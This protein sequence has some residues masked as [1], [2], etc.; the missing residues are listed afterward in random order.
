MTTVESQINQAN[1]LM[2]QL[3]WAEAIQA[4]QHVLAQA[5]ENATVWF[6]LAYALRQYGQLEGALNCYAK[7]LEYGVAQ[8]EESYTNRA[9]ILADHLQRSDDAKRELQQALATNP[10]Y[11][12]ALLN[13]ARVNE[14][15]GNRAEALELYERA[16]GLD[17]HCYLALA[18]IADL[19]VEVNDMPGMIE[20]VEKMLSVPNLSANARADLGFALGRLLDA[21]KKYPQAFVAYTAGNNASHAMAR[22]IV[23]DYD[24]H[25]HEQIFDA[26]INTSLPAPLPMP[27]DGV[28]R[29]IFICGMFRSGS[30]LLEQ[31]IGMHPNVKA[32]GELNI[33]PQLVA[34]HLIPFPQS[35]AT[36]G[37]DKLLQVAEQYRTATNGLFPNTPWFTDK[38]P[39]NFMLIGLIKA[40]FP[41]A[42]I[43]HTTRH[44]LDTCLANYFLHLDMRKTYAVDLMT[45]GH[46]YRQYARL[47][48]HWNE[49]FGVDIIRF[50]YDQF[51]TK[52]ADTASSLFA[53]LGLEWRDDFLNFHDV[54]NVVRTASVWQVREPVY[55]HSS[56]RARHYATELNELQSYLSDLL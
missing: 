22:P 32:G 19:T 17:Q 9:V 43:I 35:L 18:R 46:F 7:A 11:V 8:P 15:Q 27:A 37:H 16:L 55:R 31:L 12:P 42:V 14:D 26:L 49:C 10:L 52:P 6:N 25:Q 39:D 1:E 29:P 34:K 44:P 53:R 51:V 13:L 38:R 4:Y 33:L 45:I 36:A 47:M 54:T 2:R 28:A 3:R 41:D 23:G 40:L 48:R 5:Q 50:D 21:V 24:R 30:T 56:G 20:R